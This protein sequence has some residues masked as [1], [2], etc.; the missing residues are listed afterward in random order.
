MPKAYDANGDN[1]P[2]PTHYY[3]VLLRTKKGNIGKPI[4]D[5][6]A[7]ELIAIGFL[8]EHPKSNTSLD[9]SF[10]EYAVSVEDIEELTGHTFFPTAPAEVKS[11]FKLSDWNF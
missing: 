11:S 6:S 3:K 8:M 7:S 10:K 9:K 1:A 2:V 5:C 4:S